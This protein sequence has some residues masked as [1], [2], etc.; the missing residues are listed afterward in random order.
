[1]DKNYG[2][3]NDDKGKLHEILTSHFLL[4]GTGHNDPAEIS[5][6]FPKRPDREIPGKRKTECRGRANNA[7]DLHEII[8]SKLNDENYQYHLNTARFAAENILEKSQLKIDNVYWTSNALDIEKLYG[9]PDP[10]NKSDIVIESNNEFIGISL[11]IM[12][13]PKLTNRNNAGRGT[14]DSLIGV[15]TAHY[16][17]NALDTAVKLAEEHGIDV[18]SMTKQEA[19]NNT[20]KHPVISKKLKLTKRKNLVSITKT[21]RDHFIDLDEHETAE[22]FKTLVDVHPTAMRTY[23]STTYGT[24]KHTHSFVNPE[25]ELNRILNFH[26]DHMKVPEGKGSSIRFLGKDDIPIGRLNVKFGSSTPYTGIVGILQGYTVG[27][28]ACIPK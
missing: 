2:L 28:Q 1:M 4:Y 16:E 20:K 11:K 17:Q 10:G 3:S 7:S 6:P 23:I 18:C 9:A 13:A 25:N 27:C 26:K 8:R 22:C 24:K 12:N 15:C 5:D 19:H 21:Y 14:I